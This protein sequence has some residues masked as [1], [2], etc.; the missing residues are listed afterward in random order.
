MSLAN[1]TLA[2]DIGGRK[3][4][5]EGRIGGRENVAWLACGHVRAAR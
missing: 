2:T 1:P 5:L 4:C 3:A